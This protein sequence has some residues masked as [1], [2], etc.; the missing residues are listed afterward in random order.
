MHLPVGAILIAAR[1]H[2]KKA[3]LAENKPEAKGSEN[4]RSQPKNNP[5]KGSRHKHRR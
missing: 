1:V 4:G 3:N 2:A 5:L